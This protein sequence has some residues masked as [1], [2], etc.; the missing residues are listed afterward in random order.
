VSLTTGPVDRV[1]VLEDLDEGFRERCSALGVG[2]ANWWYR[3]QALRAVWPGIR[4][5]MEIRRRSKA[6]QQR[7]WGDGMGGLVRSFGYSLRSLART[8]VVVLVT[9]VSLGLGVGAV[10]T[11]F[12]FAN[13]LLLR[14]DPAIQNP[15]TLGAVWISDGGGGPYGPTSFPDFQRVRDGV[16]AFET[17]ALSGIDV[18]TLGER[19]EGRQL[20]L[21]VVTTE[22]FDVL[23][24]EPQLGRTF[25]PE[26][27][28][29]GSA[30]RVMIVSDD[31]WRSELGARRD[32]IGESIRLSGQTFTVVG[33]A[34]PG[35]RARM[36][37]IVLDG[38]IPMGIPQAAGR[39]TTDALTNPSDRDFGIHVRLRE[40]ATVAEAEAQLQTLAAALY[41]EDADAWGTEVG[42]PRTFTLALG[43]DAQVNPAAR[44]GLGYAALVLFGATAM[45][46]AIAW[47]NVAGLLLARAQRR[48]REIAIRA[49]LG[50]TR[51]RLVGL[52]LSESMLLGIGAS[53][54]GLLLAQQAVRALDTLQL[55]IGVPLSFDFSLDYRVL[56]FAVVL[57]V[58]TAVLFGLLPALEGS[59]MDVIAALK[60]GAAGTRRRGRARRGLRGFLVVS[61]VTVSMIFLMGSALMFRAMSNAHGTDLGYDPSGVAVTSKILLPEYRD[62]SAQAA[63]IEELRAGLRTVPGVAAV[64]F[65]RGLEGGFIA[66]KDRADL[67]IP[68]YE[69]APGENMTVEYNSV[70]PG[71][72]EALDI[73][74]LQGRGIQSGDGMGSPGIAV[75]SRAM[76]ERLWPGR[77]PLGER[78]GIEGRRAYGD[79]A[80]GAD[81]E[82]EVVGVAEDVGSFQ[83]GVGPRPYFWLSL[84]Q[85]PSPELTVLLKAAAGVEAEELVASLREGVPLQ[86]GEQSVVQPQAFEDLLAFDLLVPRI[87]SRALAWAGAFALLLAALGIY[88][89]VSFLVADRTRELALRMAIGAG[90][91]T[92]TREVVW[93]GAKLALVGV[94]IGLVLAL[95]LGRILEANVFGL[96]AMDPVA[97][98]VAGGVLLGAAVVAAVIPALRVGRIDPMN[99][100]RAD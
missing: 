59:R 36:I 12:S 22:F 32:V 85:D 52:L 31:F 11:V 93:G 23:G 67:A 53:V 91:G 84:A 8:P 94:G 70:S 40:G 9:V 45:I 77:S 4:R 20:L 54:V 33:V 5:R 16:T 48:R 83:V 50:A 19:G 80:E 78:F 30:E 29:P 38:W 15:E 14:V 43:R 82:V 90:S 37:S 2:R 41:E 81:L 55:P 64:E 56:G 68:G 46:L 10:T 47:F 97:G 17:V 3:S 75:V 92:I 88:G 72:L 49:S 26:E 58:A 27:T 24:L 65:S 21:E 44:E 99:V 66:D 69:P 25:L 62:P 63:Y 98:L 73:T 89:I 6:N 28:V 86:E 18:R 1:F 13:S 100:L 42:G 87:A 51:A 76:A 61:Q 95:P 35:I 57:S 7:G 79:A 71:Y 34:P 74:L 39:R 96:S 60:G